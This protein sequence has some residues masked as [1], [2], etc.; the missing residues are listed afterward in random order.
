[1]CYLLLRIEQIIGFAVILILRFKSSYSDSVLRTYLGNGNPLRVTPEESR[2]S[3]YGGRRSMAESP[4]YGI[5]QGS[6]EG[7]KPSM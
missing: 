6:G 7:G 3:K 2:P 1:M 5:R 4:F